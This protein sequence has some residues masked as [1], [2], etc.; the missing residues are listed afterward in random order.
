MINNLRKRFIIVAMTAVI[1]VL[2]T[3]IIT[4]NIVNYRNLNIRIDS[5]TQILE[6]NNGNFP[7]D[8]PLVD[9]PSNN[10][11][12]ELPFETR[13]Y[14]VTFDNEQNLESLDLSHIAAINK[15]NA[16]SLAN[17]ALE[18]NKTSDFINNYKYKIID[19]DTGVML[20]FIDSARELQTFNETL[21][22]SI[23]IVIIGI[24]AIFILV[25]IFSK[26]IIKPVAESYRKQKQFITDASHEIKTPLTIIDANTEVLE[27]QYGE[28][29]WTKSIKNQ[30]TRLT[31][32]TNN[33]VSL[34]KMD[35]ENIKMQMSQ[36][37]LSELIQ[38]TLKPYISVCKVQKL[39]LEVNVAADVYLQGN[40]SLL[41]Q[42][43][44][45]LIDNAI[46]YTNKEGTIKIKL[47]KIKQKPVL[48]V[49]NSVEKIDNKNL[50][51]IFERF[52]RLDES[53]NSSTGGNGIGLALAKSI[54][55]FHKG[56]ISAFAENSSSFEIKV[57]F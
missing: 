1:I 49:Y 15:Q 14:T 7:V 20:I 37:N 41:K 21:I 35:E 26:I 4:I 40:K 27:M 56:K 16:I 33:L 48:T 42:L 19:T 36:V 12:Q 13:Y 25:L 9:T 46:K 6:D 10:R 18:S 28:D 55:T 52:Y 8:N 47:Q 32:L 38:T 24:I 11:N 43:F 54:V 22:N 17:Q 34:S 44:G 57:N 39:N 3:I 23:Y 53:R 29:E 51:L 31:S 5:I 45:I 30:I 50:D 2:S